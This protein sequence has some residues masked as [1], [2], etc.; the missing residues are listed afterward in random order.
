MKHLE[1]GSSVGSEATEAIC[2]HELF[3]SF[4]QVI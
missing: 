1:S 3:T 2:L 4:K